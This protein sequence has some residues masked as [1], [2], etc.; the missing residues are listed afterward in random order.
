M[1]KQCLQFLFKIVTLIVSI[2]LVCFVPCSQTSFQ[3]ESSSE[4][5]NFNNVG[6]KFNSDGNNPSA[7]IIFIFKSMVIDSNGL[8]LKAIGEYIY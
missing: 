3:F 2:K 5:P 7:H 6:Y 8:S 4:S 1:L